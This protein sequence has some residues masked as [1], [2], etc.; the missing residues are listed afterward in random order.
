MMWRRVGILAAAA[1]TAA[2]I[3]WIVGLG[4]SGGNRPAP[5]FLVAE[6][7]VR[8]ECLTGTY[9]PE[10]AGVRIAQGTP[11]RNW[12]VIEEAPHAIDAERGAVLVTL[13]PRGEPTRFM[14]TGVRFHVFDLGLR[15][16]GSVFYRPCDKRPIGPAVEA[17]LD[18]FEHE[19]SSSA[20][21]DGTLGVGFHLP[22]RAHPIRFP[23]TISLVEPLRLYLVVQARDIYCDWTADISWTSGA[24]HGVIRIDNG[25]MKYRMVDGQGTG[26]SKP[27][28]NGRWSSGGSA[29]WI[30]VR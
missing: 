24:S 28:P 7:Q 5:P 19:I 6:S 18:G 14:V 1:L 13:R 11:P 27:G 22:H 8:A 30:G 25:G 21:R 9:I 4:G 29:A 17:D 26:W 23:W 16:I 3:V 10:E 12:R 2:G 20:D 15:P